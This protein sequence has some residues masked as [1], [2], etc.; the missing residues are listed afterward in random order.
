MLT[1]TTYLCLLSIEI[2]AL[3]YCIVQGQF[4]ELLGWLSRGV[5][6]PRS[7]LLGMASITEY[8]CVGCGG[9]MGLGGAA[10]TAVAECGC[11]SCGGAIG[12]CG[13]AAAAALLA[14]V[15]SK[16]IVSI[17]RPDLLAEA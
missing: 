11:V 12:C 13:A 8:G 2:G 10:A 17:L 4:F 14:T 15:L 3:F 6:A 1:S 7:C 5:F 16:S 9:A